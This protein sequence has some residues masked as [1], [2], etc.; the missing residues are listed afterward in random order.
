[1]NPTKPT[2]ALVAGLAVAACAKTKAAEVAPTEAPPAA[3][4]VAEATDPEV[5]S[6]E[7]VAPA[8]VI[9]RLKENFQRAYFDVDESTI[10]EDVK[11][12]LEDNARLM[13]K[14]LGLHVEVQGHADARGT[15]EYNLAL[16]QK[17]AE[18]VVKFM[19]ALGVPPD[20]TTAVSYGREK[21]LVEGEGEHVWSK[22]RRAEFRISHG[23]VPDVDDTLADEPSEAE[24]GD[25]DYPEDAEADELRDVGEEA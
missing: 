10:R 5:A 6:T 21:P 2:L 3:A 15:S 1:M 20:R 7:V 12:A 24:G 11:L 8:P 16:G 18:A 9:E 23:H 4:P 13:L 19:H 14:Y 17:R 22:N 25:E